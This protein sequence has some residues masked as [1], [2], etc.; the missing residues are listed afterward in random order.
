MNSFELR[1]IGLVLLACLTLALG[2]CGG[3]D[4][5]GDSGSDE[6]AKTQAETTEQPTE[7]TAGSAEQDANASDELL[8]LG[9]TYNTAFSK[10]KTRLEADIKA[11]DLEAAKADAAQFRTAVFE[12]DAGVREIQVGTENQALASTLLG[13]S[14]TV[15]ADLDAMS[16]A[17]NV[18]S[19]G[20]LL[21]RVFSDNKELIDGNNELAT[22]LK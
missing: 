21:P 12:Y 8:E 5:D 22:A 9:S 11:D 19:F 17:E 7:T 20:R 18:S 16:G 2:A 1:R 4:D 6:P 3:D 10:F 14:R 15:I 13:K